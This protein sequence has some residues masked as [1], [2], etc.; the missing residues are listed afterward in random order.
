[1]KKNSE[2]AERGTM[3]SI[4]ETDQLNLFGK[5][6]RASLSP[7]SGCSLDHFHNPSP[8]EIF[9]GNERLDRYLMSIGQPRVL[10]M[11]SLIFKSDLSLFAEAY[12]VR[13]RKAIHP[14]VFLGL[15]VYGILEGKWSLRDLESLARRDLG[16]MWM[17]GGL[18]P[19]HSTIGKFIVRHSDI[20]TEDYFLS[21]TRQILTDLQ[22][23][24]GDVAGDGTVIEAAASHY[25]KI[26]AEAAQQAARE[27]ELRAEKNRKDIPAQETADQ[28][29]NLAKTAQERCDKRA[30][31]RRGSE[32][33]FVS[34]SEPD[35]VNQKM[36]NNS[37]RPSYKPSV[38]ANRHR[39]IVGYH[40]DGSNESA[41]LMPMLRQH[42]LFYQTLPPRTLLDA[43]YHTLEVLQLFLN[44]D[45]D[46][47]C[48]SGRADAG[49][50]EKKTSNKYYPKLSFAY[51][52]EQD[53]YVC[54]HG[55]PLLYHNQGVDDKG[56]GYR[57]YRCRSIKACPYREECT[58]SKRGRVVRRYKGD[59]CKEAMAKVMSQEPAKKKYRQ[60][61]AMVE[62]VFSEMRGRQGLNK[63]HRFGIEKVRLEF[64][65]HCIAYNLKRAI[66]LQ[67]L[68]PGALYVLLWLYVTIKGL[69]KTWEA[70]NGQ[71]GR[72][73]R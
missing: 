28:A 61:K 41:S 54:P 9:F 23:D 24:V 64:S 46:L 63:F 8:Y 60:R 51:D 5:E 62:P 26:K 2:E 16:A 53:I 19:D 66:C 44:L 7:P 17:C 52:E 71:H 37:R 21:L 55:R 58:K 32:A 45:L 49:Q 18:T 3:H 38:L 4:P 22:I 68:I 43:S 65:L 57:D 33:V 70:R 36:K 34:P 39:L 56:L 73:K 47:L 30:K 15:I 69:I 1:M 35:A 48:P 50:W 10:Q 42:Y 13:G 6:V 40:V 27:A 59:S 14:G 72:E 67:P 31:D 11:R 12:D 20:L 25:K 29:Q